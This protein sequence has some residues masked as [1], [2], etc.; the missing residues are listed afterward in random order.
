MAEGPS[1]TDIEAIFK[2]LR[3]IP[4]N[5][6]CFD[7]GAKN[8][9]WSTVTFG[10]FICIDCSSVHRNLGVHLTFVRSTQLDTQWTWVQ[11]RSMQLGGNANAAAFF[12]QHNCSTVDA[13]TKYNSRAAILYKEKLSNL[14]L[15]SLRIHGTQLH[16]DSGTEAPAPQEKKE[17]DFFA[18]TEA[19]PDTSLVSTNGSLM[20]KPIVPEPVKPKDD[21]EDQGAGPN[22]NVINNPPAH[23]AEPKVAKSLIGQRKPA[24][25]KP[26][27]GAKKGLGATKVHTNF[28]EI[29]KEAQLAD[30][31]RS[32]KTAEVKPEEIESQTSSLRLAYQDL[33]LES[34][35]QSERLQKVDPSK[36]QQ[37]ERLGMGI[38]SANTGPRNISH[39]A[40][41]DMPIIQQDSSAFTSSNTSSVLAAMD[42]KTYSA[43][44]ES[45]NSFYSKNSGLDDLLTRGGSSKSSRDSDWD[46]LSDFAPV[47]KPSQSAASSFGGGPTSSS[48]NYGSSTASSKLSG[49]IYGSSSKTKDSQSTVDSGEAQK[50]FGSAKAI[51]S[52]QFFQDS[53]SAE[54][55]RRSNLSR[56]QGSS[57]ISSS[58]YFGTGSSNTGRSK[59]AAGPSYNIQTPDLDEVKESVRQGVTKV[60]SKLSSMANDFA[61][62]IQD[63]Y[64]Y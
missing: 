9:T 61:S 35:K 23:V 4:A 33:S 14:A 21:S 51:S 11:L 16:I 57:G 43:T 54:Q 24:A 45:S 44:E 28:D 26:G 25:K 48:S 47:S 32:Q 18:V 52:D 58:D 17:E 34:K 37:V 22:V 36:A 62:S 15:Q 12:R 55:E 5:K 20:P 59:N 53:G 27:M 60:A 40:M 41:T 30:S 1:K 50:K 10:V 13:Q 19:F 8:P 7:C 39:S 3:S 42:R 56:F 38:L 46:M 31:L 63:R 2:R 49:S 29:E 6:T 64:G